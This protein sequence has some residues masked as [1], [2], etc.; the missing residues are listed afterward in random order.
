M[1]FAGIGNRSDGAMAWCFGALLC[2]KTN[3]M[4]Q[5]QPSGRKNKQSDG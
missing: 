1:L 5:K 3:K 2:V 4:A